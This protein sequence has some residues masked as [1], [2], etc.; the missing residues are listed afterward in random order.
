MTIFQ[1]FAVY[2]CRNDNIPVLHCTT[3]TMTI[4]QVHAGIEN[5]NR[6][7]IQKGTVIVI[8]LE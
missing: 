3:V 4:Y 6:P 2:S 8:N 1:V 7:D 5:Y